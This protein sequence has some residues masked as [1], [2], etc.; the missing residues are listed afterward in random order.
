M[1]AIEVSVVRGR[2][3]DRPEKVGDVLG[4]GIVGAAAGLK[5]G[6]IL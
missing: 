2:G 6:I 3:G 4:Y 5:R 1:Y